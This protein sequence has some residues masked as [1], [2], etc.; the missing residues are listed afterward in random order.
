MI[1]RFFFRVYIFLSVLAWQAF[2]KIEHGRHLAVV[3]NPVVDRGS[4]SWLSNTT[5]FLAQL[6]TFD[7]HDC[8]TADLHLNVTEASLYRDNVS[9]I[10]P[11]T[12]VHW[13][14]LQSRPCPGFQGTSAHRVE[15][16]HGMSHLQIWEEFTFFDRDTDEARFRPK[17]E[18]LT[19]NSYSSVSGV[20]QA[21][22]NG[23][24]LKNDVPYQD[25]DLQL[26][27]ED[28]IVPVQNFSLNVL[29]KDLQQNKFDMLMLM[30]CPVASHHHSSVHAAAVKHHGHARDAP[31]I[32]LSAYAITRS[33][34][35]LLT[36]LFDVC[37]MRLDHQL[38]VL[39][40]EGLIRV[41]SSA[42]THFQVVNRTM[43]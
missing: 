11:I 28:G 24:L 7:C 42:H 18:Y 4:S 8:P 5:V 9:S 34:A 21:F 36:S 37:G 2:T 32:C 16:G 10:L 20:F 27:I 39:T 19:S 40:N 17:P 1:T 43:V 33:G 31:P 12:S 41:K 23:T 3:F 14:I 26:V 22:A 30:S 35:R 29:A 25:N 13:S 15:R 38:A 6:K